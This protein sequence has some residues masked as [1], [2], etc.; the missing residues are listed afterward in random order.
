[1]PHVLSFG[2]S[3]TRVGPWSLCR[4]LNNQNVLEMTARQGVK[5]WLATRQSS[6]CIERQ[7]K[8]EARLRE[9][10]GL[11]RAVERFQCAGVVVIQGGIGRKYTG[12]REGAGHANKTVQPCFDCWKRWRWTMCQLS[13]KC[14]APGSV[15]IAGKHHGTVLMCHLTLHQIPLNNGNRPMSSSPNLQNRME[16]CDADGTFNRQAH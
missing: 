8:Q 10:E 12:D 13:G 9:I 11:P 3:H 5:R 6:S 14:S 4:G 16:G 7:G 1:M 15:K 2:K